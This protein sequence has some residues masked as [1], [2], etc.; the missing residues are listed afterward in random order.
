M[1]QV[2]KLYVVTL[3]AVALHAV[4]PHAAAPHAVAPHAVALYGGM[5]HTILKCSTVR[6]ALLY[7]E[8]CTFVPLI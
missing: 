7:P 8:G 2:V 6:A 5:S 3:H 1:R 4:A